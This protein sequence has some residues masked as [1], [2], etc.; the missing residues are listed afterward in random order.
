LIETSHLTRYFGSLVAV[1]DMTISVDS[2]EILGLLGPNGAGK[3]TTLR[4]LATLMRPTSGTAV[5]DGHDIIRDPEQVRSIVGVV[6]DNQALY[7]RLTIY[8]NLDFFGKMHHV[9]EAERAERIKGLLEHYELWELRTSRV[10]TLSKGLGQ[11]VAIIRALVHDPCVLLLDEPT[12]NLDPPTALNTRKLLDYHTDHDGKAIIVSTHNLREAE[13]LC[14]TIAVMNKGRVVAKGRAPELIKG[15]ESDQAIEIRV[16]G[17]SLSQMHEIEK[18]M[19]PSNVSFK[20]DA[21][22][23][24]VVDYDSRAPVIIRK[25][26]EL[27]IDILE[28]HPA[29]PEFEEVLVKIIGEA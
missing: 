28:V 22:S 12:A 20:D 3:T 10:G 18:A 25:M 17:L 7:E 9:P 6:S 2:G 29:R 5:V 23:I 21:V 11:R 24:T 16:K 8:E 13:K 27:G 1:E 19:Y 14:D 4:L 26:L 15:F